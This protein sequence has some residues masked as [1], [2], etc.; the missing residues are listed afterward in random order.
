MKFTKGPW[1]AK[2][3]SLHQEGKSFASMCFH[4]SVPKEECD[5]VFRLVSAAPELLRELEAAYDELAYLIRHD[6]IPSSEMQR[7][8]NLQANM[9]HVMLKAKEGDR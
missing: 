6:L 1:E 2:R 3:F 8:G 5:A 9:T 7:L 4:I